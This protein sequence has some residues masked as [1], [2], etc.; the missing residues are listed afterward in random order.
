MTIDLY[1]RNFGN[2]KDFSR[3]SLILLI[4]YYFRKYEIKYTFEVKEIK[5]KFNEASIKP[6]SKLIKLI[7][8]LSKG[9]N[10][11][12]FCPTRNVYSLSTFGISEVESYLTSENQSES[13]IETYL[14]S[15]IPYLTK[16]ISKVKEDNKRKF[17]SE[18]IACIEIRAKRATLIL[19][20]LATL[21]HLYDFILKHKLD[22]FNIALSKRSDKTNKLSIVTKDDF[23]DIR[24]NVFIEVCRSSKIINN[25]V[26]KILDEKLDIRN[27]FAHPSDIELHDSKVV[28]FVEDLVDNVITKYNL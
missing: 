11:P 25:D 21:D 4:A 20:W 6:P 22:D 2:L 9:K 8:E 19:T 15:A 7:D 10:S 16:I 13:T 24:E 28:N 18:A 5:Q 26:R 17:L 23:G 1:L 3:K 14:Q 12:L 27:T